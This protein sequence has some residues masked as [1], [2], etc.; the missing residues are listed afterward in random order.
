MLRRSL[1]TGLLATVAAPALVRAESLMPARRFVPGLRISVLQGDP[2]Y[3]PIYWAWSGTF[4]GAPIT[5]L[6][7]VTAD[8]NQ[9]IIRHYVRGPNGHFMTDSSGDRFLIRE[10]QGRVRLIPPENGDPWHRY[11]MEPVGVA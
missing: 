3:S 5:G 10:T 7:V 1:L 11:R 6:G 9:G 8:E 4:N 2:G